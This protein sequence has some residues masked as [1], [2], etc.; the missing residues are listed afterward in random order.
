M[1]STRSAVATAGPIES[2]LTHTTGA[3]VRP[4]WKRIRT[5]APRPLVFALRQLVHEVRVARLHRIGV[6]QARRLSMDG[7]VRLNLACGH[8]PKKG[9][10]NVDLFGPTA[11]LRLDLRRPLPFPDGCASYIYAEHFFEHLDYPDLTQ[12]MGWDLEGRDAP[13]EALQFLRECRRVLRPDGIVDLVV[14]DA[15]GMI[16]DYV[17]RRDIRQQ[18]AWW[19][20]RWCDTAMHRVNYL[21]RQGRQ[22]R[23]AYDEE[24]L[25]QLMTHAG[26]R[27]VRR[28]PFNPELDAPNHAIGSLCMVATK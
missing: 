16:D 5:R 25:A 27:D 1:T 2:S 4:L 21:F 23:Y 15:E 3:L 9:W 28:R 20:P 18:G 26:F 17:R 11:E 24:T 13:S 10:L 7:P 22:H 8:L 14:P 19:G 6:R 12:S